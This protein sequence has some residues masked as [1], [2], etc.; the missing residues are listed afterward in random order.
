MAVT[1][2]EREV[3]ET[4]LEQ[5]NWDDRVLSTD[6]KVDFEDGKVTLHGH[7]PT[8]FSRMA[9]EENARSVIGV[10]AVDNKLIVRHP[11]KF[12][13]PEDSAIK[14]AI[15]NMVQLDPRIIQRI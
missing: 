10:T 6:I 1:D 11:E 8:Y 13:L 2:V 15:K 3:R 7:I 5:L 9:A 4:V 14:E 12:D